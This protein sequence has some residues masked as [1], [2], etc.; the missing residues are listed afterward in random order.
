MFKALLAGGRSS[1][2]R[3]SSSSK[4]SSRRRTDSKASSTVSRK[5]SRGDDRDRGLGDLSAY[6]SSGNR[7]K[8][9]AP[10]AAGDSV[11]SSYATAE[12]HTAIEPDRNVIERAPRR[13]DLD[14]SERRDRYPDSDDSSD[15]PRHRRNRSR[16]PSRERTS[17]RHDNTD[18]IDNGNH[19]SGHPRERRRTQPDKMP[20]SPGVPISGAGADLAQKVGTSDHPQFP[21]PFHNTH[22][23]A[24][25]P[26][27]PNV[28]GVYDPHVQQQFP[29]QFPAFVGE[30][31]Q[32]NPAGAAA[33]Y[34]GDQGQSVAQQPGVRPKPPTVIPNNQAHLMPASP[35]ANPPPEPSSMGQ[36]GAAAAYYADDADP[37]IQAPEQ[38]SKPPSGPTPKPP[39][40]TIQTEGVSGPATTA[41]AHDEG[42]PQNIGSGSSPLLVESPTP[43]FV[44]PSGI[45]PS[46]PPDTPGIGTLVGAAAAGAVTSHMIGHHHQ[47]SPNVESSPQ[48]GN[49]NYENASPSNVG[50]AGPSTYPD[51]LNAP[52]PYIA[53]A[54]ETAYAAHPLHPHHAALY[55]GA[56]FQSGG[57]AFQQRQRGPLGKFLDF[58]RDAE[59]VGMFEDYTETIGV[60]KHC[61]EPG[62][63]SRDAPRKHYYRPRRRSSDRYSNGSRVDKTSR[64]SSSED[65]GR[66]HKKTSTSSW[67][68][69]MLAGYAIKSA[70]KNRDFEDTYSVRSGRAASSAS[71]TE[72]LSTLEKRSHTSRGIYG[73]SRRRSYE[74]L[75][76]YEPRRLSHSGSRSSSRS[77]KHFAVRDAALEA[78]IEPV[79]DFESQPRRHRSSS[80]SRSP[81]KTKSRKSSSSESSF[82][83]ISR[84]AK[85]SVGGGLS[86]F[87]TASSENRRKRQAKKRR[88]IFSFNNS[89]SSSL[90]ADLAFGNGYAKRSSGKSKKRSKKKDDNN[91]DAALLG[92]G[93]TA[94]AIVASTDRRSRRTGEILARKEPP[95]TRLGYSSSATNDDA[96]EDVDSGDQSSSSVS[97]ALAF[98]GSGLYGNNASPSSDSGT[99]LWGWRWGNKKGKK[100]K[101]MRSNVSDSRFPVNAAVA[102]GVL[103]T[104]AVAHDY[105]KR[106]RRTSEDAGSSAGNL[107]HVAP[108][109]TSDPSRFD[110]VK[111]SSFPSQPALIRSGPIPLQQP[112]PVTPV[113]QAVYTSQGESIHAYTTP[114]RPP[115][116]ANTFAH[117]DYQAQGS[118][119]GLWEHETPLYHDTIDMPSKVTRPPR[120]SDSSPVFHTE[121]LEGALMSSMKRRS[122]MKDQG[123]VQFDL[124][125]DQAEKE[126]RADHLKRIKRESGRQG[127]QLIDRESE[128][129]AQEDKNRS[130]RYYEGYRDSDYGSHDQYGQEPSGERGPASTIGLATVGAIGGITAASVLSGQGSNGGSS[131]S[132]QRRHYER[133]EK[134]RAERRRVS[135]SEI[136]S[137]LPMPDRAYNDV[138]QRPNPNPE[139]DHI[140]TSV[141]SD[142]PPKKPVHHDYAQFFAPEELRHNPDTYMRR[143]PA[144]M[145]TI[146]EVEPASQKSKAT[147]EPHPE[148]R[149][150]PWPVPEL[151][152]VEPTPP[153][154]QSGSVRDIASPIPS[155][156]EVPEYDRIPKRSTTG[157]RVSWGKDETREYEVPST[158]SE[159]DSAD[160]EFVADRGQEKQT[161]SEPAQEIPAIQTDLSKGAT[162]EYGTDI[163]VAATAAAVAAAAGFGPSL[164]SDIREKLASSSG[165]RGYVDEAVTTDVGEKQPNIGKFVENEP[166]YSEPVSISDG[167]RT[168]YDDQPPSSIAQEV[169][170]QLTGEQ[171]PEVGELPG[172]A[173]EEPNESGK[174]LVFRE[175]RS[176]PE[177]PAEEVLHIP[178][179]F[180]LGESSSQREPCG[181]TQESAHDDSRSNTS[182]A[183][184]RHSEAPIEEVSYCKDSRES[185]IPSRASPPAVEEGSAIGKKKRKKR[186]SKRDSDAFDDTV[187]VTSSPA[188]VEETSDRSRSTDGQAKEKRAGGLFSNIF[189]SK[190]SEP[191][192]SRQLSS[193][194]YP[195]RD[196][197]SEVGP[198]SGESRRQRREEK[199]RENYGELADL[200][201]TTEREKDRT[202]SQD[203]DNQ[204]SFLA[205]SPEM[206]DQVGDDDREGASGRFTSTDAELAELGLDVF[207]QRPRSLS[208]SPPASGRTIDLSPRSRS[209]PNSPQ[210]AQGHEEV[211]GQQSRRSSGVR[212]TESPTAVPLHF[213]RPPTTSPRAHR[214][215]SVSSITAPSPSSP[216]GRRRPAS[217]EFISSR[218][219]RPLWLVEHHGSKTEAQPE[220]PLP[221]LPSSKTSSANAS[222]ENL[223]SLQDEKSWEKIDLSPSIHRDQQPVHVE[224]PSDSQHRVLG[225]Q[226]VTPTAASFGQINTYQL[227]RKDKPKYEFHSPSELLQDPCTYAELPPSPIIGAL[228][229][230]E[231]SVVGVKDGGGLERSLDNLPPLPVSR[232]STP[233]SEQS[234]ASDA[235]EEYL[236]R[237]LTAP[238]FATPRAPGNDTPSAD[239]DMPSMKVLDADLQ[240]LQPSDEKTLTKAT[241][242]NIE[243]GDA[244]MSHDPTS[245]GLPDEAVPV[246]PAVQIPTIEAVEKGRGDPGQAATSP[247]DVVNVAIADPVLPAEEE[248]ALPD[249]PLQSV[250]TDEVKAGISATLDE[251]M[252][253]QETHPGMQSEPQKSAV[254][255]NEPLGNAEAKIE[256]NSN[257]T[258]AKN[259]SA[260]G[261]EAEIVDGAAVTG[262]A[263][264]ITGST[265]KAA[266]ETGQAPIPEELT[267]DATSP[268]LSKK[269]KKAKKKK[270][271]NGD[272]HEQ[273]PQDT[274][275]IARVA[276]SSLDNVEKTDGALAQGEA[277]ADQ[278]SPPES[279]GKSTGADVESATD[280]LK[281][282]EAANV[283]VSVDMPVSEL[284]PVMNIARTG[285]ALAAENELIA[286]DLKA[287]DE[288][289]MQ[290]I[291]GRP[292]SEWEPTVQ[293]ENP[294]K[295]VDLAAPVN[296]SKQEPPLEMLLSEDAPLAAETSVT[297]Q[298]PN[299]EAL[300]TDAVQTTQAPEVTTAPV[301][302]LPKAEDAPTIP[303][304]LV[305]EQV[306]PKAEGEAHQES[307]D[308]D[309]MPDS[310]VEQ[311]S[312]EREAAAN[313]DILTNNSESDKVSKVSDANESVKELS[314]AEFVTSSNMEPEASVRAGEKPS[315]SAIDDYQPVKEALLPSKDETTSSSE[316]PM[317]GTMEEAESLEFSGQDVVLPEK[318]LEQAEELDEQSK[319]YRQSVLQD[320]TEH[321]AYAQHEAPGVV[322]EPSTVVL[323]LPTEATSLSVLGGHKSLAADLQ[324]GLT[325]EAST[326]DPAPAES[327]SGPS[328]LESERTTT[329]EE[330]KASMELD[331]GKI[332]QKQ[333]QMQG[334]DAPAEPTSSPEPGAEVAEADTKCQE[335][336]VI[337]AQT[338]TSLSRRS[339]KKNKKKSKRDSITVQPVE[340][341]T[342]DV[343]PNVP[344]NEEATPQVEDEPAVPPKEEPAARQP[345]ETPDNEHEGAIDVSPEK[346][347]GATADTRIESQDADIAEIAQK[348]GLEEAPE[349][350]S[351]K[352]GKKKKKNR[353]SISSD[354][355][356]VADAETQ[357]PLSAE[358]LPAETPLAETSGVVHPTEDEQIPQE[359][360]ATNDSTGTTEAV[361]ANPAAPNEEY[362]AETNDGTPP[363]FEHVPD[364]PVPDL[365]PEAEE[366]TP[367][368]KKSKKNKKKKQS[369]QSAS[370][371]HETAAEPTPSTEIASPKIDI[372]LGAE[373]PR[374]TEVPGLVLE[375]TIE[376][377]QPLDVTE[378]AEGTASSETAPEMTAAQK[379]KAKKEKRK[380]RKSAL[381]DESPAS[382]PVIDLNPGNASSERGPDSV[383]ESAPVKE[384]EAY[385]ASTEG[386][387]LV[388]ELV[389]EQPRVETVTD[390]E[391]DIALNEVLDDQ[392]QEPA[393][394]EPKEAPTDIA[395]ILTTEVENVEPGQTQHTDHTPSD[396]EGTPTNE[397][398]LRADVDGR[399]T[400]EV[401]GVEQETTD[402]KQVEVELGDATL[403]AA[404]KMNVETALEQPQEETIN[405]KAAPD[406]TQDT[407]IPLTDAILQ[408]AV[409]GEPELPTPKKSKKD[410]KK[411]KKQQSI[412]LEDD[413]PTAALEEAAQEPSDARPD[414]LEISEKPQL[415]LPDDVAEEPQHAFSEELT[416]Q[417]E[418]NEHERT[419]SPEQA[420]LTTP[421][422][423]E[424]MEDTQEPASKKK[425]KKD[426]KKRKSVSFANNE[427]EAS[428]K[429]SET[430]EATEASHHVKEASQPPEQANEQMAEASSLVQPS[431][432]NADSTTADEVQPGE[433][434]ADLHK[435]V[436]T[437][438]NGDDGS[439]SN[440]GAV[441]NDAQVSQPYEDSV[442]ETQSS[443]LNPDPT[444]SVARELVNEP[445][446]PE[447]EGYT[448]D[449]A[450]VI[451]SPEKQDVQQGTGI[452]T[453]LETGEKHEVESTPEA[454]VPE[455]PSTSVQES[456]VV[457][458]EAEQESAPS[459]SKKD[460]KKKKKRKTQEP[461]ENEASAVSEPSI[462]GA[463][464]QTEEDNRTAAPGVI[465]ESVEQNN[466]AKPSEISS[467]DVPPL[468]PES[469]AERT[470]AETE[471]AVDS[472]VH[473]VKESEKTEQQAREQPED[474]QNDGAPPMS[475]KER[476]KAKKKEKKRQSKNLDGSVAASTAVE[477]ASVV[478]GENTQGPLMNASAALA[479]D[480]TH[481]AAETQASA[482]LKP[483]GP[484]VDTATPPAEDDGKEN[485]SHGTESHGE[486]DKN[487]FWTD[488]MVSSQVDQQQA[489][490][491]DSPTQTVPENAT[492][493]NMAVPGEP[494]S[495][496]EEIEVGTE[497]HAS[498]TE[499]EAT[500]EA[501]RV[502]LEHLPAEGFAA[503]ADE[504][505]K[506]LTPDGDELMGQQDTIPAQT[507]EML[508]EKGQ[509]AAPEARLV[510]AEVTGTS[511]DGLQATNENAV[512]LSPAEAGVP[513]DLR[514]TNNG[515]TFDIEKVEATAPSENL[516]RA[517]Q[518]ED[519]V[520][521]DTFSE[522]NLLSTTS[523]EHTTLVAKDS[524]LQASS[525][526]PA[527][528]SD[529]KEDDTASHGETRLDGVGLVLN[530]VTVEESH[531]SS[532]EVTNTSESAKEASSEI[533]AEPGDLLPISSGEENRENKEAPTESNAAR[534]A[535]AGTE[536]TAEHSETNRKAILGPVESLS[537]GHQPSVEK[538]QLQ[539]SIEPTPEQWSHEELKDVAKT[540]EG[541]IMTQPLSRKA[542]KK[543]K[544]KAKKQAKEASIE[545][546]GTSLAESKGLIDAESGPE[547]TVGTAIAGAAE[548]RL[549]PE[550]KPMQSEGVQG[551]QSE[552]DVSQPTLEAVSTT[553]ERSP[554]IARMFPSQTQAT[555]ELQEGEGKD[556]EA[557][558]KSSSQTSEGANLEAAEE[559][560]QQEIPVLG[561]VSKE[562][563]IFEKEAEL[564]I[565]ERTEQASGE[566]TETADGALLVHEANPDKS[567]LPMAEA[568]RAE[569]FHSKTSSQDNKQKNEENMSVEATEPKESEGVSGEANVK[570]SHDHYH[571]ETLVTE[572]SAKDDEWPLIDWEKERV[573]AL[574]QTPQSSP[575]ACAAPFEP[576]E[577][578]EAIK[579]KAIMG[580]QGQDSEAKLATPE[581]T[582]E[583]AEYIAD[584]LAP[585]TEAPG[586]EPVSEATREHALDDAESSIPGKQTMGEP[587]SVSQKQ[588]KIASIF[589]NLERGA[590]RRP[591]ATKSS[592]SV[593]DG[594]EDETNDQGASR[595]DAMQ[596]SEA[597]IA[598]TDG[599]DSD[600]IANPL[601]TSERSTTAT[602]EDLPGEAII[603]D[604]QTPVG[605]RSV[606]ASYKDSEGVRFTDSLAREIP[607]HAPTPIHKQPSTL[608]SSSS[609]TMRIDRQASPESLCELGRSP[610]I[611]R[612]RDP[613]PR[614]K[615]SEE[616][617]S[618]DQ[619]NSTPPPSSAFG[620]VDRGAIS[621]PRTPL[622]PIAEHEPVDRTRTPIGARGQSQ[623]I[624]R[625]EMKP[626]HVLPRP[627]TPVRKFT[628]N[629]LARQAWPTLDRDGYGDL[630]T[631]DHGAARS[632]DREWTA[633]AIQT[634][635]RGILKPSSMGSIKS[636]HSAHSQRSLRRTDRSAGGDLRAASQAQTGARQSSCSP[637]PPVEPPLLDLNIEHI[638]SS[639]SYDPVTD[640]GKRPMR[641][642]TDVYESWG[643]IPNSPRSPTR[644]PSIRHRRSMQHLQELETRLDRLVSE[645]RLLVAAREAAEDKLRNASVARRKSDHAL[646]ERAADLR[647]REA[648]VEQLKNSVEWLQKEVSRLTE[649]NEGLTVTNSNI[650]VAHAAEIQTIR[651]SFNS[652]LGD[653]RLQNQQLS[654]EMQDRVR[655]EI[656]AA[657]A[658][659]N[660]ELRRLREDLESA[661][662]KVKELQQQIAASMHDSVL[663]FRDED[664]FDA[665]CQKLCGHVQQWVLRFSKHSDLRRCR[666][667]DDIQDEKIADRFEN[668]ILD[669]S[670]ADVYLSDRVR[671]RDVFMSVV[672]TMVW[673]FIFTRYLFGMDREQRQ[674]LKSLEKQLGEVG[675]RGAVHRWRATTLSLLSKRPAFSR[676]RQNDTEAVALEIF[677]TLSRLLPPPSNV[678]SQL[679]E[680]L[681]KVL[682]VAV[683]LS[684]EMRTQ[685]AE[686]I[687]L[688]PLQ[689][690]YD[691]NGDLARQ[692]YFNASLM[693]ERSGETT[694]N[695]ELESQQAVV[696]VVLFP[697]VVKKG[698]DAGEG[699]DEVV[700]CPAQVLVARSPKDKKVTRM[701][702]GDRM[703]LDG[704]RS[705]HSIAP[706]STMD[707]SNVI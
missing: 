457:V 331:S 193:D 364:D 151:K 55:H 442:A 689:P 207:E 174:T 21:P 212:P 559:R 342:N 650:T 525:A 415:S 340:K 580:P 330:A 29:G 498:K 125:R 437:V 280:L 672:M 426:K 417:S 604:V 694:S 173:V 434:S 683:N 260:E 578:A 131:E 91:V 102:A 681:R 607:L 429:S 420:D 533:Q 515:S 526:G 71:D 449:D 361:D 243:S 561:T 165:A 494:V 199:R 398:Q 358:G 104:A 452:L 582:V 378:V 202:I 456:T 369:L 408:D 261:E 695:E 143:E 121:S 490:P 128:I 586:T 6:S 26:S 289:G 435:D 200:D 439:E 587:G 516:H 332:S 690:E 639:S 161:G 519:P 297:E 142:I 481:D 140:K 556:A 486:N 605:S 480:A 623:G 488:H 101:R 282:D 157:S 256:S 178:G 366:S 69:G 155:P 536:T 61:F 380:Q 400:V 524:E 570:H 141:F 392:S 25:V 702:S 13:R 185:D 594:A 620:V 347:P 583:T 446:V 337:D 170:Q 440:K 226:E 637:Q 549:V 691:T 573:D 658:Q 581:A 698:N 652:E 565:P 592:E 463:F 124:T 384:P 678:E 254:E 416:Q 43:T 464:V 662:D 156:P 75:R 670:D 250:T 127:V 676:Q 588:S 258:S 216:T 284:E 431:Q 401:V 168:F 618:T 279:T 20:L 305:P 346:T 629:A 220:E 674:K 686:Y 34:Y 195:S 28:P 311:G 353:K 119:V 86:S 628:D 63:S 1:D 135:G 373:K 355:Q 318:S 675:P 354:S 242:S 482:E 558:P 428:T 117:Y 153:Q 576:D 108:V 65:E 268:S 184:P 707:M 518:P 49:Q 572:R 194:I 477:S 365:E 73:R 81:R 665:A 335:T 54:G 111:V 2:A 626:E 511:M 671:R 48:P 222:A 375:E 470:R 72:N 308:S 577:S 571:S 453:A 273:E 495:L 79:G 447:P 693:N 553:E 70:F 275:A 692:V 179:G 579:A 455:T 77:K 535:P 241:Q 473:E 532:A 666:K 180:E 370:D 399:H 619:P 172:R 14:D 445:I 377:E 181:D 507:D 252:Q 631:R 171:T 183:I 78:A 39:R 427:Q 303:D 419:E 167:I 37:G 22:P 344:S 647:D 391:P 190:V 508:E 654:N 74:D 382:D 492:P 527:P 326:V 41:T 701:L 575:E 472:I 414:S 376:S 661:R 505:G 259:I 47:S 66:R 160:H 496:C 395:G 130:R 621:P 97:S 253:P 191:V 350:Q 249:E 389:S 363:M 538:E 147:E 240:D 614:P 120:R 115:P 251:K 436:P 231:G 478:P 263:K 230:A 359:A 348:A 560:I 40:P 277:P 76:D 568:T 634:P 412:S 475:A 105:N 302:G 139:Q 145:P 197:Q 562:E 296:L 276:A 53:G 531:C 208:T 229:S 402:E 450:P 169:I 557:M 255:D 285:D 3:S 500:S 62:T 506:A 341:G 7:S 593:K 468:T 613:S 352:K 287:G 491:L 645:N 316:H 697:L 548:S 294:Q 418:A 85:K 351:T 407:E 225:S 164:V 144:S 106:G 543:Q 545:I 444:P 12:P 322:S 290:A 218:E 635:E 638:A 546:A 441:S 510:T 32:P 123:S 93:A 92:L 336:D 387:T 601:V 177:S 87:F 83:D 501:D 338:E 520:L 356:A 227:P 118:G 272:L 266:D 299:P 632:M 367:T 595:E 598:T 423:P 374:T 159:L 404:P 270:P 88:S 660:M 469:T 388:D 136:S 223:A 600:H 57:L 371:A 599:K 90:D 349:G 646:N 458:Q 476:K 163:E 667:L 50:H 109:P 211:Q 396:L 281:P 497:D 162:S 237:E 704:T 133:S 368:G 460:K 687:M 246:P 467:Q 35:H 443:T 325:P 138:D 33:D 534:E 479:E 84:P 624:P 10:S 706:S 271:K 653:L 656:D 100:Q 590:F 625:L 319:E 574:E 89:S 95:S 589:P 684:I 405:E 201:K 410:K 669:G 474:T 514:E 394:Q 685:L 680:S 489:T 438:T 542:S 58:W 99:S 611:Q 134:R 288:A 137:G 112:Q 132:S 657:L 513:E 663:V 430:T 267:V 612:S 213:R 659:K 541:E 517:R 36:T 209:R 386:P 236:T 422:E 703:S 521:E 390:A 274:A 17:E 38:S 103:G 182:A 154:S 649:E 175:K 409:E 688:P 98:G 597:P 291:E 608:I 52:P 584:Q 334:N 544:K 82:V 393:Q 529:A 148:Y 682:R 424:P 309:K 113:S 286:K 642:M 465:E 56:P 150:L 110:A 627:E 64:Y 122:T 292:L 215:S 146:I 234:H 664:Y 18:E 192:A 530:P 609:D 406:Q 176:G 537:P 655:Q 320:S 493:E 233:K 333:D 673:E 413:Q 45:N 403:N 372:P 228:P 9:Y 94:T 310:D 245:Q 522:S 362:P 264:P 327:E 699:E 235:A 425:A 152:V 640:K 265:D 602:L 329:T 217:G 244:L 551:S 126:Q 8:R 23:V 239:V 552:T 485:Q 262:S 617:A 615:P 317:Q 547:A 323:E 357:P 644:P 205:G 5:S 24:S 166:V 304:V 487:L 696:R 591:I 312:T 189:G 283:Q 569:V 700:V 210:L 44:P 433:T 116:F 636:V 30:P 339:S 411:K 11:A 554:R 451:E 203:G 46:K 528:E 606:Q 385:D 483:S 523:P 328:Q 278:I 114:S 379:K 448:N 432:E 295:V 248:S 471:H 512:P 42:S 96:W 300:G 585:S 648:E 397:E 187:S 679:L 668:A 198:R 633:E 221:S 616:D 550:E 67:L 484:S 4:S 461:I 462:E 307:F 206:P 247:A 51:Q 313:T 59:G 314:D 360:T 107:Q 343:P 677:E 149:G 15:K 381:L 298:K 539:A 219:M 499:Q 630:H 315:K 596:V 19:E 610:S 603:R 27:S 214:S 555:Q 504:S 622:Q 459:K 502:S 383:G 563:G 509:E 567:E 80:R 324:E 540:G 158:S 238:D 186:R 232:P 31:Y 306:I 129:V 641:A 705:I 564:Q 466:T 566:N 454:S 68:P 60:C 224:M 204:P 643:E 196:V 651:T 16:S 269:K 293:S 421:V 345:E 188:R 301:E 257:L 321:S 503:E